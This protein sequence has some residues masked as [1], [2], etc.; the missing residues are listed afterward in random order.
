VSLELG[1]IERL[2]VALGLMDAAGDL[3]GDWFSRPAH[4]LSSI[5]AD[6]EQREALLE[7]VDDVLGGAENTTDAAG[8]RWVP[9][10]DVEAGK[11]V[12]A[13]VVEEL[14][15][16]VHIGVGVRTSVTT[17]SGV[18]VAAEA[19]VPLFA[20]LREGGS[21]PV[22]PVLLGGDDADIAI[23]LRL[24]LPDGEAGGGVGLDDASLGAR[25]P[26]DGTDSAFRFALHGLRLPGATVARDIDV[27]ADTVDE[28][29][30]AVLD[31]L[32]GLVRAAAADPGVAG[33]FSGLAGMLGLAD[34]DVP[35]FP[36]AD[37][38]E[39][40]ARALADWFA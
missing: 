27:D 30:D 24:D 9:V 22:D 3:V 2:A 19:M 34:D 16:E 23:D 13:V 5:L 26:T 35:D 11:F 36:I 8:R 6:D 21:G 7:F 39:R 12:A 18:G 32:L 14:E 33:P 40:G 4:Y 31:L 29:D 38:R 28:L 1:A 37:L 10:A 20:T 15:D 25:I 17:Q